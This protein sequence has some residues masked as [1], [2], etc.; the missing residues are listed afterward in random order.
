MLTDQHVIRVMRSDLESSFLKPDF[1][2]LDLSVRLPYW[3][4][5]VAIF[6]T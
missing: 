1:K 6:I 5:L 3:T 2:L 4:H